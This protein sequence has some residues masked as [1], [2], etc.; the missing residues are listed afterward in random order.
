MGD[1]RFHFNETIVHSYLLKIFKA[2]IY[3]L[4]LFRISTFMHQMSTVIISQQ[5]LQ[6]Y[7]IQTN[8]GHACKRTRM[9]KLS[10]NLKKIMRTALS[11]PHN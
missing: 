1:F 9:L 5:H 11:R 2:W 6:K 3:S 8:T 7:P 4:H 10:P